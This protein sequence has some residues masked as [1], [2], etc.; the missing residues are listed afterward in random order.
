MIKPTTAVSPRPLTLSKL[1]WLL[2][3]QTI[4]ILLGSLNRLG[5]WTLGYITANEF[6]RWVD[7]HNMLTL[8]LIS[9]T[10]FYL[11]KKEIE[12]N[13]LRE[14][15]RPSHADWRPLLLN[16]TFILGLYLLATGYGSHETTNYLHFRFCP[17]DVKSDLCRIVI[18]NDDTFSHWLFFAGFV[19]VNG[20][21]MLLQLVHPWQN[22]VSGRD[23]AVLTL[24]A[25]F[26]ALGI[27]ANLGFEE[28]GLDLYVVLGLAILS[29]WL[30]WR[31]GR[32]P[33]LIYYTVA[34]GIGLVITAVYRMLV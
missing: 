15:G 10:A 19:L 6:L 3:A 8:P 27:F 1:H 22:K 24:N 32:Q 34:Y 30:L 4:I 18:F 28:I 33:L 2:G 13:P 9:V 31:N 14:N 26:V 20:A 17:D 5:S 7:F 11:L 25:F 12:K 23:T 16:L 29:G 21:L